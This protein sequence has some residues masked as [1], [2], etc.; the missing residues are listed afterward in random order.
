M[1]NEHVITEQMIRAGQEVCVKYDYE[2]KEIIIKLGNDRR[3]INSFKP[4]DIT[5]IE[6]LPS[7]KIEKQYFLLTNNIDNKNYKN[8]IN[9]DIYI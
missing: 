5:V 7:D 8:Y 3:Y 2:R 1:T 4:K 6:I 9:K